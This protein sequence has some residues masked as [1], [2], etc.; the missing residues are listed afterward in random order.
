MLNDWNKKEQLS[1]EWKR[2]IQERQNLNNF[3][4]KVETDFSHYF[5]YDEVMSFIILK[6]FE[7]V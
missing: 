2:T 5:G 4:L 7:L 3:F 1:I 6:I